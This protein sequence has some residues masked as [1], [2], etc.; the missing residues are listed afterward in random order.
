MVK[1]DKNSYKEIATY[2]SG[3]ITKKDS[4]YVNIHRVNPLYFI[5]VKVDGFIEEKEESRYLNF[6]FTDNSSEVLKKY[7]ELWNGIKI[8]IE[9]ID[10]KPG[11]YGKDYMNVKFNSDDDLPVVK[12]LKFRNLT[13]TV[14]SIFEENG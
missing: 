11:E 6:A 8:L 5:V 7:T 13:I 1:I 12:P 2:Y 14:R 4:K 10:N 3:Y 9:K